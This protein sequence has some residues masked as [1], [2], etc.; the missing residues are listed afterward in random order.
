M[1]EHHLRE[2][3]TG[4]SRPQSAVESKR[5]IDGQESLDGE[6]RSTDPLLLGV[7]LSTALVQDRV[8][9]TDSV[10]GALN[11]DEVDGFLN[12]WGGE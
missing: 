2:G 5:L 10:V 12:A 7:H 8:D 11:L 1:V 4:G 9:T 6:H 3:L